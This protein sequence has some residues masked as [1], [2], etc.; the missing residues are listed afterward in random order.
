MIRS[1]SYN[2]L[3]ALRT[4]RD[5]R[6]RL[7]CFPYAGGSSRIYASWHTRL[8]HDVEVHAVELP[9]RGTRLHPRVFAKELGPLVDDICAQFEGKLDVPYFLFGH[10]MGALLAFLC[11][12][13]LRRG[14][15]TPPAHLFVSG[16]KAPHIP[17]PDASAATMSDTEFLEMLRRAG[18]TPPQVLAEPDL[19]ALFLPIIRADFS[20]L[21][22]YVHAPEPPLDFPVTAFGGRRDARA[23]AGDLE[24]WRQHATSLFDVT[25]FDGGHFFIDTHRE[26]VVD[27]VST[28]IETT[29]RPSL[30]LATA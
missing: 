16:R 11:A 29:F 2:A 7:F 21:N 9:G 24:E 13:A 1:R 6:A 15:S 3:V 19:M 8:A 30:R 17:N 4:V 28:V 10:S 20:L 22:S 23:T 18:G 27:R 12:R 26:Q 5:A 25:L 14:T